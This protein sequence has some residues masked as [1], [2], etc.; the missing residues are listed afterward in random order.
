MKTFGATHSV[1]NTWHSVVII[2][3]GSHKKLMRME[4]RLPPSYPSKVAVRVKAHSGILKR[5]NVTYMQKSMIIKP[6]LL[7]A[8]TDPPPP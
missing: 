3:H 4:R 6:G 5:T 8:H 1:C 7:W 2:C